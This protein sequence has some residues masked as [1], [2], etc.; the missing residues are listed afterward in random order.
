[1]MSHLAITFVCIILQFL[2]TTIA[3]LCALKEEEE[4][5]SKK[6]Q[7]TCEAKVEKISS[8]TF[9]VF[10]KGNVKIIITICGCGKVNASITATL[11][12]VTYKPDYVINCGVAGGFDKQQKILDWV[13]STNFVYH[14]VD[15]ECLGFKPGQLLGEPTEFDASAKLVNLIKELEKEN[16]FPMNI[17]YGTIAS[18]DQFVS[19]DDQVQ[20]IQK[21]FPSVICVEMEGC[22]IAH[23]CSKFNVPVL[24]IRALSDIAVSEHDNSVDFTRTCVVAS[25]RAA[26]LAYLIVENFNAK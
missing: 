12:I 20:R 26:N 3:F 22:A 24:A 18:G 7:E 10:T 25:E 1:M 16:K 21:K 5:I 6:F 15:I 13:I 17:F 14:D 19:T 11:T 4:A 2:M 8:Y 9:K 23:A